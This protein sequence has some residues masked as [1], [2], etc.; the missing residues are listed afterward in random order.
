MRQGNR[1]AWLLVGAVAG[2][3]VLAFAGIAGG[4]I[5]TKTFSSGELDRLIPDVGADQS[6]PH[7]FNIKTKRAKVKD[8]NVSVRLSHTFPG[9]LTS[10]LEGPKGQV[11]ELENSDDF[12]GG[13]PGGMGSGAEN[14]NGTF[15]VF[16]DEAETSIYD[17][18]N[19]WAGQFKPGE[20][21]SEFDGSK[22]KGK[23]TFRVTDTV[24]GDEGILHCVELEIKYKK[25]KKH[26]H[27]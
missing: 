18:E 22:L 8:V 14:C 27:H 17:G 10:T 12:T 11:V 23:W 9:D 4:K 19:P 2:V 5:K 26:H 24:P 21:L 16:N 1:R 6:L 20:P 15:T 25:K 13:E 7:T 3:L